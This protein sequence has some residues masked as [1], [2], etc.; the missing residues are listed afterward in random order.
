M[1]ESDLSKKQAAEIRKRGG[2]S[3]KTHGDPR[4]RRGLPDVLACYRGWPIAI[5]TK[6]PGKEGTLTKIQH[7]TL[8]EIKRAGGLAYVMTTVAQVRKLLDWI[9]RQEDST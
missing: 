3:V 1:H 6:M 5:E 4:Q 9:D 8:L 7:H 2:W